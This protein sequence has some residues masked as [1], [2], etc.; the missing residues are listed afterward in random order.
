MRLVAVVIA[1]VLMFGVL[2]AAPKVASITFELGDEQ[3]GQTQVMTY[4]GAV[5]IHPYLRNIGGVGGILQFKL[6]SKSYDSKTTSGSTTTTSSQGESGFAFDIMAAPFVSLGKD[7][8]IVYPMF[9][10]SIVNAKDKVES[11]STT[12][13][14]DYGTGF[15][16]VFG[17][18]GE[19]YI[20]NNICFNAK[21]V[22]RL[23]TGS[24]EED[25]GSYKVETDVP[26]GGT[27]AS[28]GFGVAF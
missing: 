19:V 9:G 22:Q 5:Y 10:V 3:L 14:I 24:Y 8:G 7:D 26:V 11:G 27:E 25:Y 6:G 16:F 1:V 4:G 18:G 23:V 12:T 17:L 15:G 21:V 2:F 13:E 20:M 28:F